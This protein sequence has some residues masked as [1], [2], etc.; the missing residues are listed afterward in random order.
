MKQLFVAVDVDGV[1]AESISGLSDWT[2]AK[3]GFSFTKDEI[4]KRAHVFEREGM[5]YPLG[6]LF[7]EAFAE[8]PQIAARF[9]V[10]PRAVAAIHTLTLRGHRIA[11]VSAR[12]AGTAGFTRDWV[13][14]HFG[15]YPVQVR[16]VQ[17]TEKGETDKSS[18]A[19][20]VLIDDSYGNCEKFVADKRRVAILF[21]APWNLDVGKHP[22]N[23]LIHVAD[24]WD[25]TLQEID[26]LAYEPPRHIVIGLSGHAGNGK[27]TAASMA[28][29]WLHDAHPDWDIAQVGFADA[30]K[31]AARV[32]GWN[33]LKDEI[34]RTVLQRVGMEGRSVNP[35]VWID[36]LLHQTIGIERPPTKNCVWF[37]TDMRFRNEAEAVKNAGGFLWRIE[38]VNPDGTPFINPVMTDLQRQHPSETDLDHFGAWDSVITPSTIAENRRMVLHAL[39]EAHLL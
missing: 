8:D 28:S 22:Q 39:S 7:T 34:G 23:P 36:L 4:L 9:A 20:D 10:I 14:A 35:N 31:A 12:P 29:G 24:D 17:D 16:E 19:A 32:R 37:V 25:E 3:Y 38:R 33:G 13:E 27:D 11:F 5:E 26:A 30:V 6:A 18:H 21:G 1:V 2:E 15:Q